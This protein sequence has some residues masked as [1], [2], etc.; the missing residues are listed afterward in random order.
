MKRKGIFHSILL[1]YMIS[2][3]A[4]MALLFVG[5]GIYMGN[6][7]ANTVRDNTVESSINK[8]GI[9]RYRHEENLATLLSVGKQIG[10]SPYI[11][12]FRM[13]EQPMLAYHLKMQLVPYTMTIDFCDQLYLIFNEDDYLYSSATSVGLDMFLYKLMHLENT[14]PETL[15]T[16]LRRRDNGVTIFPAQNVNSILTDGT[17][18]RM[19]AVVAPV[20]MGERYNTGNVL[21][22]IKES[23]YQ[24]MFADEIYEPRN[25]YIFYGDSVLAASRNLGVKD[26]AV[27]KEIK[28]MTGTLVK[29]L[30]L[31][32]SQYLLVA[33]PGSLFHMAYATLLPME[34]IKAGMFREQL[35]FGLFLFALAIPCM[36]LTF[37]FSRRHVKPIKEL[38][39]L[40]SSTAP[41][42][43]DFEAIQSGI[44]ALVDRNEA[45][46]TRL[47][48]SLPVR[49][50]DFI[51][52]FVK[53]RYVN[54]EDAVKAASELSLDIAKKCFA[55]ALV[56]APPRD[57]AELNLG[58]IAGSLSGAVS[59]YYV[60]L[61]AL[62]QFLFVLFGD[63]PEALENWAVTAQG[64][65]LKTDT[66]VAVALSGVHQQFS[67]VGN[68]YLEASTAYDNRFVM[69]S[70][71]VLRFSDVG[72]A[73]KDI[74]PFTRSY[75]DSFRKALRAGDARGLN[76][77]MDELFHYLTSTQMSLFAFRMIYNSVIGAIL[78]EHFDRSGGS[79]DALQ[80]YDV[81][82]LS[83]CRSIADLDDLLRKLC[84]DILAKGAPKD[85]HNLPVIREIIAYM[86]KHYQEPML[87]MSAIADAYQLSAVRLSL[88]FKELT[89]MS[90]SEYLL[91]LRMEKAKE[92]LG[93]TDMPVKDIGA[94][95]GYNDASGFIRRFRQH[96]AMTPAQYRQMVTGNGAPKE[97]E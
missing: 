80:L 4:I 38:R 96:M 24:Q 21:F 29:D 78:S 40:F 33:Q 34:T 7:Y 67:H 1:R 36:A 63:S 52:D 92:L 82:T 93:G 41:G 55:V 85:G 32:G 13:R 44:E 86:H 17:N 57:G 97:E 81:F 30:T 59:G 3:T 19:V 5:V 76:D 61:L 42:K 51:K 56:G 87:S 66:G 94:A 10:L 45:L 12:A 50:A 71:H 35:G 69:G 43:D 28:G 23:T 49:R 89:G 31:D 47:V 27:L 37:Y 62:E 18:N 65:V 84:R 46:R 6:T 64:E 14:P 83:G 91:L 72:S 58:K 70:A 15:L 75:L 16:A 48:E 53:G 95:V 68:A 26:E 20:R 25:T 88:D 11:S 39:Y 74:V 79:M 90:P 60:E 22:L 9:I 8:L 77:R 73:A 2:Y 54:R